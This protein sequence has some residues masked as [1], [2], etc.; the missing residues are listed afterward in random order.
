[1]AGLIDAVLCLHHGSI[2][3]LPQFAK[4]NPKLPM[5]GLVLPR[6]ATPWRRTDQ[7]RIAGVSSFGLSGTN[8]HVVLQEAPRNSERPSADAR[9]IGF[10]FTGQGSQYVGMAHG[11]SEAFPAFGEAFERCVALAE[12]E[13]CALRR[14]L[15][16]PDFLV[17]TRHTQP[18]LFALG[19]GLCKLWESWGVTP[20]VLAGH[21]VGEW[22]AM[23]VA[24]VLSLEDAVRGVV[25][26]GR[27]IQDL[28]E[29]GAMMAI[30][31]PE[32]DVLDWILPGV[33][34]ATVNHAHETVVSGDAEAIAKLA[35]Q[36]KKQGTAHQA[37]RVSHA[38]HS[39]RMEPIL[40]DWRDVVEGLQWNTPRVP[41]I[42]ALRGDTTCEQPEHW[43]RHLREPVHWID[44]GERLAKA[45][46]AVIELGPHPVLTRALQRNAELKARLHFVPGLT[47]GME[48][49][50]ALRQAKQQVSNAR[51]A[52]PPSLLGQAPPARNLRSF[53][54][55]DDRY[56]QPKMSY[57]IEWVATGLPT[58]RSEQRVV[59]GSDEAA[60]WAKACGTSTTSPNELL[61]VLNRTEAPATIVYTGLLG[62]SPLE[63]LA[64]ELGPLMASTRQR[65][66]THWWILTQQ[67]A[68]IEGR[69]VTPRGV[70]LAAM[71]RGF[72]TECAEVAG[73]WRDVEPNDARP[74]VLAGEALGAIQGDT[75]MVPRLRT[76]DGDNAPP[77]DLPS[78]WLLTGGTGSVGL[79][80]AS[81]LVAR[82]A[83]TL[84]LISRSGEPLEGS[85][86]ADNI[87]ALRASGA[88]VFTHAMD[89]ADTKAMRTLGEDLSGADYGVVH[90]AG[91]TEPTAASMLTE[92]LARRILHPKR[93]GALALN[94]LFDAHK[95]TVVWA[96]GSIAAVWGSK[97]LGPY[98]AA[99]GWLEGWAHTLTSAGIDARCLQWGPWADSG[100][101]DENTQQT[102]QALGLVAHTPKAARA[103]L[104]A[105]LTTDHRAPVLVRADWTTLAQR[106]SAS[107]SHI[108]FSDLCPIPDSVI[109][110]D[111]RT[112]WN[113]ED[114]QNAIAACAQDI[115]RAS[116]G[117]DRQTPLIALG[118]DSL[119]ATELRNLLAAKGL[120]VPLGRLL[121]GPS[122]EELATIAM[123]ARE[124]EEEPSQATDS[125][126]DIPSW[127]VW[128][129][130]AALIV[131]AAIAT[132]IGVLLRA[133]G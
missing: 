7:P 35:E 118:L 41:V 132:A 123:A 122:V 75:L 37:L 13:G 49:T 116:S 83:Q 50:K 78:T 66:Q 89:V 44:V 105:V 32:H 53:W 120:P 108:L 112:T 23:A 109:E 103:A 131:G 40:D 61:S 10:V 58:K 38:F 73:G 59:V 88:K 9:R 14:A 65:P 36:L 71:A 128:T 92:E 30:R 25:L 31:A 64:A 100:M 99:N 46:D 126:E 129:H 115:L 6:E 55:P 104:G 4:A 62:E 70:A 84:H 107:P 87:A 74:E 57:V 101:V 119:M 24:E 97:D 33:Q 113:L 34:I 76:I 110:A 51:D 16:E 82:G 11:L 22:V 85:T 68:P 43:V 98:A 130:A 63:V 17:Q 69:H 45:C 15:Q 121:G 91:V 95:P 39:D 2:P 79:H 5:D 28:P 94:T 56:Q 80:L 42:S 20:D 111:A 67:G 52:H 48:P 47:R 19:Y 102:L 127:L 81:E 3:A 93:D 21:S 12:A 54:L 125:E 29:G 60:G 114:A 1:M 106:L 27:M 117:I 124:R 26:R 72:L 90:A 77:I 86:A 133:T 8:A 96:M 18:A